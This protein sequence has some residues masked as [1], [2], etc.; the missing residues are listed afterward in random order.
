MKIMRESFAGTEEKSD[1][2][3]EVS[4]GTGGLEVQIEKLPHPRFRPAV[5]ALAERVLRENGVTDAQVRIWDFGALDFVLEARI[6]TVLRSAGKEE[7]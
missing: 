7:A 5:T 2:R 3:V 4:P 6:K 1:V